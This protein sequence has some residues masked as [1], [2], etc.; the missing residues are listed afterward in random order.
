[1]K[2]F[3]QFM[4]EVFNT[5]V[6]IQYKP[7]TRNDTAVT[8]GVMQGS[9]TIDSIRYDVRAMY[10]GKRDAMSIEFTGNDS[11]SVTNAKAEYKVFST[12]LNFIGEANNEFNPSMVQFSAYSR[13]TEKMHAD[14]EYEPGEDAENDPQ[15]YSRARLYE[16]MTK[17]YM[18]KFGF[19][20]FK[21]EVK[22]SMFGDIETVFQVEK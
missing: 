4:V 21:S 12:V 6:P 16:R 19:T 15:E 9:F 11:V 3:E 8:S 18:K 5:G 14:D 7:V 17:K 13:S 20:K 2:K 22:R 10:Y 1:M